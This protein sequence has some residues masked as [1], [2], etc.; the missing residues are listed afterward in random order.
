VISDCK[1]RDVIMKF[2]EQPIPMFL[3]SLA[4]SATATAH[5]ITVNSWSLT[6]A[7]GTGTSVT[8]DPIALPEGISLA[9]VTSLSF[10]P[11]TGASNPVNTPY[12]V[13]TLATGA[14]PAIYDQASLQYQWAKSAAVVQTVELYA[15]SSTGESQFKNAP[16]LM[17]DVGYGD[18]SSDPGFSCSSIVGE[19]ASVTVN[20]NTYTA[21]NPC[22]LT[23]GSGDLKFVKGVLQ[24]G[25]GVGWTET[26]GTTT[27]TAPEMDAASAAG[28]LTFL[29]GSLL[30]LRDRRRNGRRRVASIPG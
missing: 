19:T 8:M 17:V 15:L 12:S 20:G 10:S 2:V 18:S 6:S 7:G 11:G 28:G 16:V 5:N 23:S 1:T 22:Q 27:T 9:G 29:V 13:L 21:K 26:S 25:Y 24:A 3:A 4:L 14:F 30:V